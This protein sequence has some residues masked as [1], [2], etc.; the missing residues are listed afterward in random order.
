M[1]KHIEAY[2]KS[3]N[4]A[5][6]VHAELNKLKVNNVLIEE[7][8][9]D[10]GGTMLIPFLSINSSTGSGGVVPLSP[11]KPEQHNSSQDLTQLLQF[12]VEDE[13]YE[14]ALTILKENDGYGDKSKF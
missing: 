2:F 1:S 10:Y 13:D 3:E 9:K 7:M 4:D 5:E 14:D 12:D 8:P 6:S 11:I